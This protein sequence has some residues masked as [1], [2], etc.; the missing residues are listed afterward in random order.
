MS[1]LKRSL[2]LVLFLIAAVLIYLLLAPTKIDPV[3][4]QPPVPPE[5]TGPYQQNSRLSSTQRLSLGEGK[6]PEDV[7]LDNAGR[8]YGG[9]NDGRIMQLQPDGAQPRVFANTYGRPLGLAFDSQQHLIVADAVKGLLSIN[10]NGEITT[11]A[12]EAEGAHFGCLNDLDIA[13][14]GTI[15]FTEASNKFP[16]KE[17]TADILEHRPNG[18]L[19][20]YD[21][22]TQKSRTILRN[23]HFANGVAVSPDQSF[24][25]VNETGKYRVLRVWLSEPKQGQS[26]VFI[27][28]LPG[29]PDG[30]SSNG[31]DKFWLALVT[32]R[33][34]VLDSV[35]PH[36]FLRK[37]IS[38]L[39]K[40]LQPKP[41]RYSFVIALNFS[42]QVVENLQDPSPNCY[43]EIANVVERNGALYFGSIG[44]NSIG[45]FS[46]R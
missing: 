18:R 15:Y 26:D 38:R 39:P 13:A 5:L 34:K 14:D 1:L 4:W 6:E 16:M 42:G 23:I 3:A 12:T 2:L 8:I 44:E 22:K 25:L 29:F 45:K 21:P 32:P 35:L 40:F 9:F 46:L 31:K 19:L 33:N 41:Q 24:V 37:M 20:A 43:A 30:I 27:E 28:N 17:F 7:A 10:P 36:P 11:L